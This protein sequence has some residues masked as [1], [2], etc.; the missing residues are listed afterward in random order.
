[1]HPMPA[2]TVPDKNHEA[3]T[4]ILAIGFSASFGSFLPIALKAP[5]KAFAMTFH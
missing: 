4:S 2:K 1:M 5:L 3:G